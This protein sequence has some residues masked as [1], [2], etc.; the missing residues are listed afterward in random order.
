M[1][2]VDRRE[3]AKREAEAARESIAVAELQFYQDTVRDLAGTYNEHWLCA[4]KAAREV[5]RLEVLFASTEYQ[6]AAVVADRAAKRGGGGVIPGQRLPLEATDG[7][8]QRGPTAHLTVEA[9]QR[10]VDGAEAE[11]EMELLRSAGYG[12]MIM[13]LRDSDPTDE[14]RRADPFGTLTTTHETAL[15]AAAKNDGDGRHKEDKFE[16]LRHLPWMDY[17]LSA[18]QTFQTAVAHELRHKQ[19]VKHRA[20]NEHSQADGNLARAQVSLQEKRL[21]WKEELTQQR[22]T[23]V[24]SRAED[25]AVSA[26]KRAFKDQLA[27]LRK[28]AEEAED[29]RKRVGQP[30][31]RGSRANNA[32]AVLSSLDHSR[33]SRESAMM[34]ESIERLQAVVGDITP[35]SLVSAFHSRRTRIKSLL[36][37]SRRVQD[38]HDA[39]NTRRRQLSAQ[40]DD[41]SDDAVEEDAAGAQQ[42]DNGCAEDALVKRLYQAESRMRISNVMLSK[43]D[44][45]LCTATAAMYNLSETVRTFEK[46]P[47]LSSMA[48][49]AVAHSE[50]RRSGPGSGG[51]GGG[52]GGEVHYGKTVRGG[53]QGSG[54]P[55]DLTRQPNVTNAT[56]SFR[57]SSSSN[58]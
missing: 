17:K 9:L 11:A 55:S 19:G 21:D 25:K 56:G 29:V 14:A 10:R 36:D 39:L 18:I 37:Q 27:Q 30:T 22:S 15:A 26:R 32:K 49:A 52:E 34:D 41:L 43:V 5:E 35:D 13:R 47:V 33:I 40:L 51:S 7:G 42:R 8:L 45:S 57:A 48:A 58:A 20:L 1:Q 4:E 31:L 3:S 50:M 6:T 24:A 28:E 53:G 2:E 23:L 16:N 44:R 46:Y 54:L 38:T 12:H